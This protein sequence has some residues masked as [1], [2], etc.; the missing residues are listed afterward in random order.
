MSCCSENEGGCCCGGEDIAMGWDMPRSV[1]I[2]EIKDENPFVKTFTLDVTMGALPGQFVMLWIPRV[3]EKPF[4]VSF[5]DGVSLQCSI[6][7]VGPFTETL[8]AKKVGDKVGIRGP[9]GQP[10]EY[11]KGEHLAVVGGGYGA[12]PLYFL[13]H[14]AAR[15]GCIVDFI[16][17]AR[18]SDL[19]LFTERAGLLKNTTVH[20]ATDDGSRGEKGFNT[21]LLKRVLEE[22]KK[23]GKKVNRILTVGPEGMMKAVSNLAL[24]FEVPCE[25]SVERYMKCGFGVCGQ[26]V[27]DDS[28]IPTCLAG[29]VMDHRFAR[30]QSEFGNYHRDAVGRKVK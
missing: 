10:F 17:G 30:E 20:I 14:E 4:S 24:E 25:V 3:N 26:C 22:G 19:L 13:A 15:N 2:L 6:A 11:E 18:S 29:P 28:G 27:I 12:A 16:V 8:F 7:K 21:V 9:Y 1:K 5:D 23:N